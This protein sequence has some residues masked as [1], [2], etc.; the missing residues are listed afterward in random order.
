MYSR[1]RNINEREVGGENEDVK[2]GKEEERRRRRKY[3]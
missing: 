3:N 1:I 2:N